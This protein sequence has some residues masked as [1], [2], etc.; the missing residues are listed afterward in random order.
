LNDFAK[1]ISRQ[2]HIFNTSQNIISAN[3]CSYMVVTDI[4]MTKPAFPDNFAK[5]K[6]QIDTVGPLR[7]TYKATWDINYSKD[8]LI[9]GISLGP[10]W[11]F[12]G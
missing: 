4:L 12:L 3:I 1:L 9:C 10:L 7:D 6:R 2:I 5:P 11:L 8:L